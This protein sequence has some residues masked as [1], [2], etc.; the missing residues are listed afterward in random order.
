MRTYDVYDLK[1]GDL[2]FCGTTAECAEQMGLTAKAFRQALV[3]SRNGTNRRHRIEESGGTQLK[4]SERNALQSDAQ[5]IRAWDAF[6][7]PLRK[8]FGIPVRKIEEETT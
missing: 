3:R 7:E 8:E 6:M 5:A 1:T 4:R 2:L